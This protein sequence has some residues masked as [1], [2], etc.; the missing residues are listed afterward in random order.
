[1][2]FTLDDE[3]KAKIVGPAVFSITKSQNNGY[4]ITLL[5]GN[6]FKIYN[7]KPETNVEIITDEVTLFQ[8]KT[9]ILDLQIAK[10]G[11]E[12]IIKNNGGEVK[13]STKKDNKI[14]ETTIK[15]EVISIQDNDINI[16]QDSTKFTEILNKNNISE[17]LSLEENKSPEQNIISETGTENK[18]DQESTVDNLFPDISEIITI[19]NSTNT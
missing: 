2:L 3:A 10:E 8:D 19:N 14:V 16:L 15:K 1:M 17:T 13:V 9:Q 12:L 7:E 6:F 5:E 4:K 18:P 11:S